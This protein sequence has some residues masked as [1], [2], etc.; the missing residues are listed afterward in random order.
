MLLRAS[1]SR[2]LKI[3]NS[4]DIT[5]SL[6]PCFSWPTFIPDNFSL[7]TFGI[8]Y[9]ATCVLSLF[10]H[11]SLLR[12]V[13]LCLPCA[14]LSGSG[15]QQL[16]STFTVPPLACTTPVPPASPPAS[17]A[18]LHAVLISPALL[19]FVSVSPT[20]GPKL[21]SGL[22]LW[23]YECWGEGVVTFHHILV[24]HSLMQPSMW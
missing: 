10:F 21:V 24:T 4:G 5:A 2:V 22:Q 11:G 16:N 9:V 20:W 3:S 23:L 1:S 19:Q 6:S 12:T 8:S 15:V 18:L 7:Y 14:W 13:N 17:W